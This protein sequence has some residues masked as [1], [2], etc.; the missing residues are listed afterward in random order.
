[1]N[2]WGQSILGE[3]STECPTHRCGCRVSGSQKWPSDSSRENQ[4]EKCERP[5]PVEWDRFGKEVGVL[6][7]CN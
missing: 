1:M 5:D 7:T 3:E 4:G 2:I 6:S